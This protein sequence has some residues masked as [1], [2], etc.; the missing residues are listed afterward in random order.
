M[1]RAANDE[2]SAIARGLAARLSRVRLLGAVW[3][4]WLVIAG[5]LALAVAA[6]MCGLFISIVPVVGV[7][8]IGSVLNAMNDWCVRRGRCVVAVTSVAISM[9]HVLS[10]VLI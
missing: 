10:T 5:C 7:A 2:G 1:L 8:V 6:R 3:G 9:D 4:R